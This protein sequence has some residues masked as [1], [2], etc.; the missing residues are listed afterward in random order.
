VTPDSGSSRGERGELRLNDGTKLGT[1]LYRGSDVGQRIALV[2]SLAM[3]R[4]FWRPVVERLNAAG[5]SVLTYD[6][7]GHGASSKPAGPYTVALFATDLAQL[8]DH[9]GWDSTVVAGA[10]MGGCVALAFAAAHPRRTRALGLYDTTAWYGAEA[11]QQWAERADKALANGLASL[12]AFQVTRWFGDAFRE[13]HPDIVK[14]SV[15]IFLRNDVKA[16]AESCRMLGAADAR[17]DLPKLTMPAAIAVGEEDYATPPA[18]A[19][20]LH[21]DLKNSTLTII[22]G[23]R[24]LTPLEM[25][26]RIAESLGNLLKAVPPR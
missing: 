15:D 18:M 4:E 21:R 23:G 9:F 17:K 12:T 5:A 11:P 13:Q 7:R 6:C 26:D 8:L 25:P 2:H 3:D 14:S 20:A 19:E 1:T 22:K 16:Y 24:H 10:S